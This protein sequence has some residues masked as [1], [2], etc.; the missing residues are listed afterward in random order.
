M[1]GLCLTDKAITGFAAPCTMV[2]LPRGIAVVKDIGATGY[3]LVPTRRISGVEDPQ[4]M[5]PD[6]PNLWSAAWDIRHY[7]ARRARRPLDRDALVMAVN[8]IVGRTQDQLHIHVDCVRPDVREALRRDGTRLGP[9]WSSISLLG[10]AYRVRSLTET[11]LA[12]RDP[13]KLVA[14]SDPAQ[15][16][17]MG[18]QTIAVVGAL[19]SDGSPGFYLLAARATPANR[20]HAEELL[21]HGCPLPRERPRRSG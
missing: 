12:A 2:D 7:V 5:K 19:L 4:L 9:G 1:H 14:S 15:P 16:V 21:D 18:E 17:A 3:L 8:A 11:D 20:G 6:A 13:F 10:H